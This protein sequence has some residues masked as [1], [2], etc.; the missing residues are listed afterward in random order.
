[1]LFKIQ[2]SA[3][4]MVSPL[5]VNSIAYSSVIALLS[6]GVTLTYMTTRVPNFAQ[7]TLA[8]IS[9]Y[10]AFTV[11]RVWNESPYLYGGVAFGL[12]GLAGLGLY[13]FVM[14]PLLK[15]AASLVTLMIATVG[16]DLFLVSI[17]NIYADY[18]TNTYAVQTRKFNI[19]F[20]DFR[21]SAFALGNNLP[22][23][24]LVGPLTV[25]IL[26]VLLHL[27]LTRT[28]FGVAMRATVE[29]PALAGVVGI[30]IDLVYAVSWFVSGGFAGLAG[31]FAGVFLTGNPDLGI[32][33]LPSIF[34]ASIVGGLTNIYGALLGGFIAGTAE[35]LG[36]GYLALYV[37]TEILKY[38]SFV[39]LIFIV[40][41][42][43]IAPSGITGVDWVLWGR[44]LESLL[45]SIL[46]AFERRL[47][48]RN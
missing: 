21:F 32:V 15:R 17:I 7:G 43:L 4:S 1:M 33:L 29:N 34:A 30:N 2:N 46:G 40:V 24:F 48:R 12:S 9:V 3:R 22:G 25:G 36:T 26:T 14:R 18:L 5:V 8:T 11:A 37:S 13:Y 45:N 28:K 19:G 44:R 31:L 27:L 41:T 39:P 42:L 10:L 6:S 35:I 23:I 47:L 20:S 16:Y 38:Q